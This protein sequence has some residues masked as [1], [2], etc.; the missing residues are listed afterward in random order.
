[1][2]NYTD[3]LKHLSTYD[4]QCINE[5]LKDN[6]S[7]HEYDLMKITIGKIRYA[8]IVKDIN[9]ISKL[10]LFVSLE[11]INDGKDIVLK[12]ADGCLLPIEDLEDFKVDYYRSYSDDWA[13]CDEYLTYYLMIKGYPWSAVYDTSML[14]LQSVQ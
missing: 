1:M 13:L 11:S 10:K 2:N 8:F 6:C 3:D 4:K 5:F 7:S 12:D 14:D 9:D